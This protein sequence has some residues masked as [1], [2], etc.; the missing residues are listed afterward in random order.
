MMLGPIDPAD[1]VQG[2]FHHLVVS[3]LADRTDRMYSLLIASVSHLSECETVE[4]RHVVT[5][6][7]RTNGA[8]GATSLQSRLLRAFEGHHLT[9]A[10]RRVA[11]RI[12]SDAPD[13][14]FAHLRSLVL[15][16]DRQPHPAKRNV[17]QRGIRASIHT[18]E[19]LEALLEEPAD[20][21]SLGAELARSDPLVL[22][23]V[24]ASASTAAYF[25]YFAARLHGDVRVLS[26]GGSSTLDGLSQARQGGAEWLLC[27]LFPRYPLEIFVA[28]R[29][30]RSQGYRVAVVTDRRSDAVEELSDAVLLAGV[31]SGLV[32]DTYAAPVVLAGLLL[33]AMATAA[34]SRTRRRLRAYEEMV[35]E[36]RVFKRGKVPP[37]ARPAADGI[38][39]GGARERDR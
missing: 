32:V 22:L 38:P 12:V 31:A 33:Q 36:Q 39:R 11:D 10:H 17:F 2:D 3:I 37:D 21:L 23:G 1:E 15:D 26:S 7:P 18:L 30:A 5:R 16:H 28:L 14:I 8:S 13:S 25:A 6:R 35:S 4:G 9:A 34:P 27:F 19:A 20:L 29:Y 24:R